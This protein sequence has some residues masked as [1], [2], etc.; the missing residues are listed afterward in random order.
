MREV[1]SKD[2]FVRAAAVLALL[3]LALALVA[4]NAENPSAEPPSTEK[5]AAEQPA[6]APEPEEPQYT[7]WVVS[8]VDDDSS[9]EGNITYEIAM[10]LEATNPSPEIAGEYKGEVTAKTSTSGTVKGMPL[11]ADA[12]ANS[13]PITFTLAKGEGDLAALTEDT[14]VYGGSGSLTMKAAGSGT[15]GPAGGSFSN[16]SSQNFTMT[17]VGDSITMKIPIQGHTYTFEGTISGR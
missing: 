16:T 4:C 10:N 13:G 12:I 17:V 1:M 9:S 14:D 5:P 11:Q 6:P 7:S 15:V 8:I 3:A 2:R